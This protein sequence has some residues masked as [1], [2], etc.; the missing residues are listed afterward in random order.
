VENP[1]GRLPKNKKKKGQKTHLW[2]CSLCAKGKKNEKKVVLNW[3]ENRSI[4]N[5]KKATADRG[6][7]WVPSGAGYEKMAKGR[8]A[9]K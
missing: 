8:C 9:K 2:G 1:V 3:G 4:N 7:V 5:K 6:G